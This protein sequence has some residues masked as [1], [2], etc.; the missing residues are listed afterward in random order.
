MVGPD[1][2]WDNLLPTASEAQLSR[3]EPPVT[4]HIE[5]EEKMVLGLGK[6]KKLGRIGVALEHVAPTLAQ[7]IAGTLP[8]PLGEFAGGTSW[9]FGS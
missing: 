6:L 8:G 4:A 5:Q 9:G 1:D 2:S 3:Q 7:G